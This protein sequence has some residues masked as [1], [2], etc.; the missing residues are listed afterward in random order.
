MS[1]KTLR[2]LAYLT[3]TAAVAA[4]ALGFLPGV[5]AGPQDARATDSAEAKHD[6]GELRLFNRVVL[7]IKDHYVDPGKVH[8]KEMLLSSLDWVEKRIAEVLVDEKDALDTG[9]VTVTVGTAT[10]TFDISKVDTLWDMS[11]R[12]KDIFSF[13]QDHLVSTED[14]QEI[15]Y[16][17]INGMLATLDPH[18]NLLD[19]EMYA[20]MRMHTRGEFGGL[21]FVVSMRDGK[22]TVM[23]VLKDTPA[24]RG[25]IKARDVITRIE[26]ESTVNMDLT[27]AVKR[28]RGKPG[29]K[30]AFWVDRKSFKAPKKFVL[31][32]DN[33]TIES[34]DPAK[35]LSD[36]VGYI[37]ITNFQGNTT[38]DLRRAIDDLRKQAGGKLNGL[39]MDL[40][41][42][43]G[44]LLDQAIQVSDLFV[45]KG[46]IVSTVGAG[47][48]MR[49]RREATA[50]GTMKDLPLV[51]LV[52][53]GSASASEIVTGAMKNL[54]RGLVIG[55]QTFG[56]GSVQV[57]YD[58]FDDSAL[59]LTI[60][61]YLTA[62]DISIQQIGVTPDIKLEPALV[63]KKRVMVFAPRL[64]MREA[65]L[66]EHMHD[67]LLGAAPGGAE[68]A[69][70]HREATD[71]PEATVTFLRDD[72]PDDEEIDEFQ[73][74]E[75]KEDFYVR[76]AREVLAKAGAPTR[77]GMLEK[78]KSV[79]AARER[80]EKSRIDEALAG[81]GVNWKDPDVKGGQG[82]PRVSA[83]LTTEKP[84]KA[85]DTVDVVLTVKNE[86]QAPLDRVRAWTESRDDL[87]HVPYARLFDR[88]EFV[89]G[90]LAPGESRSWSVP[91]EIPAD[92]PART[93]LVDVHV[94]AAG[95]P[96]A[97]P[98]PQTLAVADLPKPR[99]AFDWSIDDA[100]T[101]NGDGRV[102]P[103]E[104]VRVILSVKNLGPGAAEDTIA[105]IKNLEDEKVYISKGRHH[106]GALAPKASA[107]APMILDLKPGYAKKTVRLRAMVYDEKLS[108][109]SANE[110]DLPV[111]D[112]PVQARPASGT[113]RLAEDLPIRAWAAA[114]APAVAHAEKGARLP[115][116]ARV[117]EF[118]RVRLGGERL[119]F[120]PAAA[121]K[122]VGGKA[123]GAQG[124]TDLFPDR[125]P[126]IHLAGVKDA[127]TTDGPTLDLSGKVTDDTGLRD[128]YV[129]LNNQKV[130]F[131]A[132]RG[133]TPA[134]MQFATTI[135]LDE[136][137]NTVV[138]FARE[139][140][141][142]LSRKTVMVYRRPAALAR[143]Q[144]KSEGTPGEATGTSEP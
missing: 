27:E 76:F 123:R 72:V 125:P 131:K 84:A 137:L 122:K 85:G 140:D 53:H 108:E 66:E 15:E 74:P 47:G 129:F 89:F 127:V 59:K 24:H 86:G 109:L 117:G 81:L 55:N 38:H 99:Y 144:E 40:R 116:S 10:K 98:E 91:V 134:E 57:L 75:W 43:P 32:R 121:A 20:D 113:V 2:P 73:E 8:P 54:D 124:V 18:S 95:R 56:K 65:D 44:G 102:S 11:F 63:S 126:V 16:A 143:A 94:Q 80:S 78:A 106:I 14:T 135:P 25:G 111:A 93:E 139:N 22:L 110:I 3:V 64:S 36:N 132:F 128:M 61:E 9:R 83:T 97:T 119:G 130:F 60:A 87:R 23:K 104:E 37:R 31:A 90:R 12:L 103:G 70:E 7:L 52:N 112:T 1:R 133:G 49:E 35:L 62:G 46:T 19:P 41:G 26:D 136:G 115:V 30:V 79:I 101:G 58:L 142:L 138:V 45:D 141:E 100:K 33:I 88:L 120:V 51:V 48:K 92:T 105:T 82:A 29:S 96:E 21:G 77:T 6:L 50:S 67:D 42:N 4:A 34:I 17:A 114:D 28:L 69:V 71:K 39:V 5:G 13:I 118:Y 68:S 107:Q